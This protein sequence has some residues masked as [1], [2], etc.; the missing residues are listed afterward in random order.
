MG[1]TPVQVA[2]TALNGPQDCVQEIR[3]TYQNMNI[4]INSMARAGGIFQ[5]QKQV[6]LLGLNTS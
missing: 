4:L 5:I 3:N 2:A 1:F 6:C